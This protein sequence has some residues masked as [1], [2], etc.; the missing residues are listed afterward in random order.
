MFSECGRFLLYFIVPIAMGSEA[1][2]IGSDEAV[3]RDDDDD[4]HDADGM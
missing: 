1:L 2:D 3:G 4:E